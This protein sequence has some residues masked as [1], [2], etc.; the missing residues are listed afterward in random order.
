MNAVTLRPGREKSV[1]RRHPWIFS[2]AVAAV[3]GDPAPGAAVAVRSAR[4][5]PLGVGFWSPASALRVRMASFGPDAPAP[6][7]AWLREKLEAAWAR[8]APLV[9]PRRPG[10]A[11]VR[12]LARPDRK[13]VV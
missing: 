13:S 8:R 4:G 12:R 2:G 5:E 11:Q 10:P 9:R 6:G 1:L 7:P 3:E